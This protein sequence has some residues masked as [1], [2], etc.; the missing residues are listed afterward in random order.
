[1][2]R[3]WLMKINRVLRAT[4][5]LPARPPTTSAITEKN[6]ANCEPRL[7]IM[8]GGRRAKAGLGDN[9][10]IPEKSINRGMCI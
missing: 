3:F 9:N 2:S 4:M 1:M 10:I 6:W 5:I 7:N 8:S